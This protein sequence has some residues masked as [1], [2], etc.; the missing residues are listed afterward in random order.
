MVYLERKF[1]K[2]LASVELV[3]KVDLEMTNH[4]SGKLNQY[5]KLNFRTT[6]DLV[7]IRNIIKGK[8]EKNKNR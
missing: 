2:K 1:E 7:H 4:L 8:V 3:K 6:N 5:I